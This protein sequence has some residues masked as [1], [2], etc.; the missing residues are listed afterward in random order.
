[1]LFR[2]ANIAGAAGS[3][4]P[5]TNPTGTTTNPTGTTTNPT[6]TTTNPTGTTTNPTGTTTNPTGTTTNPTGTATNPG[7]TPPLTT[8]PNATWTTNDTSGSVTVTP[9]TTGN[10]EVLVITGTPTSV[11]ANGN[12]VTVTGG[13]ATVTVPPGESRNIEVTYAGTAPAAEAW[14]DIFFAFD[15]PEDPEMASYSRG[16]GNRLRPTRTGDSTGT[17]TRFTTS[18]GPRSGADRDGAHGS[19]GLAGLQAWLA[20]NPGTLDITAHASWEANPGTGNQGLSERRWRVAQSL[21][22]ARAAGLTMTPQTA[23]GHTRAQ[24]A[25]RNNNEN[26][27][28]AE[29]HAAATPAGQPRVVTGTLARANAGSSTTP[30]GTVTN[31]GTTNRSTSTDLQVGFSI[32]LEV[33]KREERTTATYLLNTEQ[34]RKQEIHPAGQLALEFDDD[35]LSKYLLEADLAIAFFERVTVNA[36]T[37]A[38]W[39]LDGVEAVRVEIRYA[40]LGNDWRKRAELILRKD[41]ATA[42]WQVFTERV[43]PDDPDSAPILG[44][45]YRVVVHF[46]PEVTLGSQGSEASSVGAPGADAEGWIPTFARNLVINPRD[47]TAIIPVRIAAGRLRFDIVQQAQVRVAYGA[48]AS[49]VQL[50]KDHRE[51]V[52]VFRPDPGVP[53]TLETSGTLFYA[54]GAQVSLPPRS[55]SERLLIINEPADAILR[56]RV[57]LADPNNLYK[58]AIVTLGYEHGERR[59]EETLHLS[60][61]AAIQ[62]WAVRL[63]DPAARDWTW[64]A[65]L[66]SNSGGIEETPVN[67]GEDTNLIVGFPAKKVQEVDITLL[68]ALPMG[69]VI[70]VK[71]ELEYR[72]DANGVFWERDFLFRQGVEPTATWFIAQKDPAKTTY[73]HRM[74]LYRASGATE[75]PWLESESRQLVLFPG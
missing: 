19:G 21:V 26:D 48:A 50:D 41:S 56:V 6:G 65:V 16:E 11:K 47:L 61:H 13:R 4:V 10:D 63:E 36:S 38:L 72:D 58:E 66:V 45:E 12:P 62:E 52:L 55:W 74:T 69:D 68:A 23:Q 46:R 31:A 57:I 53:A 71:L 25:N 29:I 40:P 7:T 75:G 27:R 49:M 32:D 8:R 3:V 39:D 5:S 18:S 73:R 35:E 60:G 9:A 15:H 33:I 70:G 64:Q 34:A 24:T 43:D 2:S 44:Y 51:Q 28:I 1:M 20:A 14:F 67:K 59:I 37:T 22:G 42:S 17:D 54:D 30:T